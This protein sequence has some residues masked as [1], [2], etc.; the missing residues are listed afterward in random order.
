MAALTAP[1]N[2]EHAACGI[3]TMEAVLNIGLVVS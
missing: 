1:S 2:F 3:H